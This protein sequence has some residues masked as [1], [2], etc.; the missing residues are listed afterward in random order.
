LNVRRFN[1]GGFYFRK[2]ELYDSSALANAMPKAICVTK[3]AILNIF[4]VAK[5]ATPFHVQSNYAEAQ[6]RFAIESPPA[7]QSENQI[8]LSRTKP[9][10]SKIARPRARFMLEAW[11]PIKLGARPPRAQSATPSSPAFAMCK[12]KIIMNI[13]Q[14]VR[15]IRREGASNRSRGGCNPQT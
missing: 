6:N 2:P 5:T 1:G 8:A 12:N 10:F 14:Y 11:R 15:K 4:S 13:F 3:R 7:K 9:A